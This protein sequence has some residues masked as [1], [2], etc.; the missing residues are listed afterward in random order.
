[1]Y[2]H[3][4]FSIEKRTIKR[5]AQCALMQFPDEDVADVLF[6]QG[7]AFERG[8]AQGI[9]LAP[10][11]AQMYSKC[12]V[13]FCAIAGG[14]MPDGL[15]PPSEEQIRVGRKIMIAMIDQHMI[16]ALKKEAPDFFEETRGLYEGIKTQFSE[17]TYED[18]LI[19]NTA[20]ESIEAPK[21]CSNFAAWG[22]A[23][24][25]GKLIHGINL[26]YSNFGVFNKSIIVTIVKPEHGNSYLGVGFAGNVNPMS[27]INEAGLSYGEMTSSSIERSWPQIPHYVQA[28]L[29]AMKASTCDEAYEIIGR[30]GG[31]TGFINMI[32]QISP[33]PKC[34][35][36]EVA[37]AITKIRH[38]GEDR[39]HKADLIYTTNFFTAF[40]DLIEGESLVHGQIQYLLDNKQKLG[41]RHQLEEI[42]FESV[43]NLDQWI[44]FNACPRYALYE[45]KLSEIYGRISIENAIDIQSSYPISRGNEYLPPLQRYCDSAPSLFGLPNEPIEDRYL[46][47]VYSLIVIPDQKLIY[48]AS[49]KEPAQVGRFLK[50]S[51]KD[52]LDFLKDISSH[53]RKERTYEY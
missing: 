48:I 4:N 3:N 52:G 22:N 50:I 24:R 23:T 26:D 17:I 11:I 35:S 5:Y 36:I 25:D 43:N 13:M 19:M 44:K 34:V 32:S 30:T 29:L 16:P 40:S 27:F 51:L 1:M 46:A 7:T 12:L 38:A 14:Y 21:G 53:S 15:K 10:K 47:S 8:Y 9:L 31:T 18:V 42:S 6:L 28:K 2:S 45:Q 49:G 41:S 33:E 37:G 20:P 39:L